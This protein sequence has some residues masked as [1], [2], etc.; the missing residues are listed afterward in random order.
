MKA[1]PS[2]QACLLGVN[3]FLGRRRILDWFFR[4][5][6]G[7]NHGAFVSCLG[8]LLLGTSTPEVDVCRAKRVSFGRG[9]GRH[10]GL[11]PRRRRL[12]GNWRV[13]STLR[14]RF[15][16]LGRLGRSLERR[17]GANSKERLSQ[18]R[19]DCAVSL[20]LVVH[21]LLPEVL[22]LLVQLDAA[23]EA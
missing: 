10:H 11:V 9:F 18:C 5:I 21:D 15:L 14:L 1:T 19:M 12:Q 7:V 4:F 20:G 3:Q 22:L 16:I 8:R 23:E 13:G 17:E 2:R 6:F